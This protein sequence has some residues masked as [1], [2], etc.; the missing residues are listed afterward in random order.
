MKP[1]M[2]TCLATHAIQTYASD[3]YYKAAKCNAARNKTEHCNVC[4]TQK[5]CFSTFG[6]CDITMQRVCIARTMLW[7]V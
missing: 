6:L 5:L 4:Y 7:Q 3:L 2:V 1:L